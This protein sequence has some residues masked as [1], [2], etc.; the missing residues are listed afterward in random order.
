VA[1]AAARGEEA[2][3]A[4]SVVGRLIAREGADLGEALD[5][6]RS[7]TEQAAGRE[8]SFAEMRAL[9]T[10]WAEETTSYVHQL[11]CE[12]PLNGLA[13]P[14][15]LRAR[16]AE[17]YRGALVTGVDPAGAFGIA[18]VEVPTKAED[19]FEL[20]LWMVRVVDT[21]RMTFPGEESVVQLG[22]TRLGILVARDANI[23]VRLAGM[24]LDL[25]DLAAS[26]SGTGRVTVWIEGL[27]A[28]IDAAAT[29]LDELLRR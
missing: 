29:V 13:S 22:A 18:V 6:L 27:P 8:P 25:E 5:E 9:G 17:V 3:A 26:G 21:I 23:G 19:P 16:L 12:D 28:G 15:H 11:S 2:V 7:T 20:A 4:C 1:E 24:R 10:A 14:A